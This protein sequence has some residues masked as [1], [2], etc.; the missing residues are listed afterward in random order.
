MLIEFFQNLKKKSSLWIIF[1]SDASQCLNEHHLILLLGGAFVGLFY[2]LLGVIHNMNYV[3]FNT[4]QV[5]G[6]CVTSDLY[7]GAVALSNVFFLFCFWFF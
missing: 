5:C 4:V 7:I 3:S 2:S 1:C 6:F